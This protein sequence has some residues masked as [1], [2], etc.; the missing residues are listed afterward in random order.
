M[1]A[2]WRP[3]CR[4]SGQQENPPCPLPPRAETRSLSDAEIV[5]GLSHGLD[6]P[7]SGCRGGLHEAGHDH[8]LH[9][10]ARIRSPAR[11]RP[12]ST[13]SA[14]AGSRRRWIAS[15][16][17]RA[18]ARPWSTA[19]ARSMA[20]GSTARRSRATAM[21]IASS[22]QDG[23]IVKMDVWNDSA[24][25][26]LVAARG[27]AQQASDEQSIFGARWIASRRLSSH[28]RAC[29]HRTAGSLFRLPRHR[30]PGYPANRGRAAVPASPA[31]DWPQDQMA[32]HQAHHLVCRRP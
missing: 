13:R 11:A 32:V 4:I 26:I 1:H 20:N 8:H 15:T 17:A 19:S 6:D 24:E 18:T 12:A 21:S 22:V 14:I 16:S 30:A 5:R 3:D 9:R 2:I 25:R 31:R 10:R 28:L 27:E 23:Q 29:L 7:G